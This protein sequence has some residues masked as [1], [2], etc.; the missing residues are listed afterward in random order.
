[1]ISQRPP[2]SVSNISNASVRVKF[3]I[4]YQVMCI[5]YIIFGII[6]LIFS[7][8]NH[9][10]LLRIQFWI[11]GVIFLGM[12]EKAV[13]YAEY[14]SVN[15]TGLSVTGANKFAEAVSALKVQNCRKI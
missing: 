5:V 1:M 13:Y 14:S 15:H 11:G 8:M 12:L 3:T 4:Y 10:E 6:W 9:K 7:G 2:A